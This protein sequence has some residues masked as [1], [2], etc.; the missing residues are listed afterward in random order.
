MKTGK[1]ITIEGCE[2]VGKSTQIARLK[3]YLRNND[4]D[5]VFLREPGG[6]EISECIRNLILS[7]DHSEMVP[8]CETL[9]YCAARAQLVAETILPA[10]EQGKLVVCDRFIDSTFAYQG[11]ARGLGADAIAALNAFACG[12]VRPDVTIW[13]DLNPEKGFARKGG[14][15]AND[16]MEQQTA[17]FHRDV[18]RGYQMAA[19]REPDRITRI[20]A[21]HD[22]E[23]VFQDILKAL[24]AAG[25]LA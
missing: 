9:L 24:R 21:S 5:A 13:L 2:G 17:Q 18:Y 12:D 25:V 14:A 22:V 23:T 7:R 20:D 10:L 6:T 8:R 16:R 1:L 3:A 11:V 4:Y 19:D 15:D